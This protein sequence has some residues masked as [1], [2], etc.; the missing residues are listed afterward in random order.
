MASARSL[1]TKPWN[2]R[3][4]VVTKR[5][6]SYPWASFALGFRI[7]STSSSGLDALADVHKVRA[8]RRLAVGG[9]VAGDARLRLEEQLALPGVAAALP[10]SASRRPHTLMLPI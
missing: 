5:Y 10:A 3:S 1:T 2:T 9:R 8:L 7:D 4:S 6:V